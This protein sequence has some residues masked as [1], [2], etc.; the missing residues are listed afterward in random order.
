MLSDLKTNAYTEK[1]HG[2]DIVTG[3]GSVCMEASLLLLNVYYNVSTVFSTRAQFIIT[4]HCC[5]DSIGW[6]CFLF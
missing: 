5:D 3:F 4:G 2:V 6:T 1:A